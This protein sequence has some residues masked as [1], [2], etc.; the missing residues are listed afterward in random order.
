MSKRKLAVA[1]IAFILADDDPPKRKRRC[2]W[3][4]PWVSR[5]HLG[6][7]ENLRRELALSEAGSV[8]WQTDNLT[9]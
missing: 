4:K 2:A 9:A 7:A 1:L 8:S 6:M 3:V 5:K